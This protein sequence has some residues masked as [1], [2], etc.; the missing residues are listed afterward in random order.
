MSLAANTPTTANTHGLWHP[1]M[2][3]FREMLRNWLLPRGHLVLSRHRLL[4]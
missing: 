4:P 3:P 2:R 1:L